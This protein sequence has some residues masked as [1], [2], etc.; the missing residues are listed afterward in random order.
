MTGGFIKCNMM[1][2]ALGCVILFENPN[3]D[4]GI[5]NQVV[6]MYNKEAPKVESVNFLFLAAL[7]SPKIS[8]T[9]FITQKNFRYVYRVHCTQND[10]LEPTVSTQ[11]SVLKNF[12]RV[13]RYEQKCVQIQVAKPNLNIFGYFGWFLRNRCVFFKTDFCVE[14]VSSSRSFWVP[15]TL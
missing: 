12:N 6:L 14:T 5:W 2:P 9:S 7:F 1:T 11:K 13:R 10:R 8:T 3:F 4:F 15:W